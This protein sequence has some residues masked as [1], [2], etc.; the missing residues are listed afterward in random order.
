MRLPTMTS[1]VTPHLSDA[2]S[3]MRQRIS[4]T[5]QEAVTGRHA[6]LARHLDGQVGRAMISQKAV[7][8]IAQQRSILSLR[9]TRLDLAQRSLTAVQD[10]SSG[11]AIAL[12]SA[13]GMGDTAR[14]GLVARDAE[15]ALGQAFSALNARHGERYLFAGDATA[16]RPFAGPGALIADIRAI[17]GAS[18]SSADFDAA[19]AAYFDD[20]AGP[21][22]QGIYGGTAAASDPDSVTAIDPAITAIVSG[23]A[24]ISLAGPDEGIAVFDA[25]ASAFHSAASRL[26]SGETALTRLRSDRGAVQQEISNRQSAL[27]LEETILT[28]SFNALTAR[29]QYEAA[30]ELR[31]LEANLEASYLLTARLSNLSLL[32]FLR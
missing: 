23:L 31:E 2:I 5:S 28:R 6:D 4:Q 14:R 7:D 29:D 27:D 9:E 11:I 12:E 21:W 18:A 20:P 30:S 24:V 25:D 17:A 22:Q 16:S 15:A 8:D 13:I 3:N 10:V 19:V 1:L 26:S 32:N